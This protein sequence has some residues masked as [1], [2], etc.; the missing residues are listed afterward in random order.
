MPEEIAVVHV[1]GHQKGTTSAIRGNN[2]ADLEAQN[3]A[4]SGE[5]KVMMILTPTGEI[6]DIPVFSKTEDDLLRTGAKRNNEGQWV[7]SDGRQT[8]NKPLARKILESIRSKTHWGTQVLRDQFLKNWGCIGI[9]GI[10]KQI[11]EECALCQKVNR[12]VM[13]KAHQGG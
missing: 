3:A 13:R 10:A 6:Q 5:E 9:Y 1:W 12:K 8:L 4:E 2:L 7:L 11:T